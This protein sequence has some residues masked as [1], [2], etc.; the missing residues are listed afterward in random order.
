[1]NDKVVICIDRDCKRQAVF[2]EAA[3]GR[4]HM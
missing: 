3:D 2:T 4:K 1:M